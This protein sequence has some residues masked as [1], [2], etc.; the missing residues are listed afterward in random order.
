MMVPTTDADFLVIGSGVAGLTF[1][2]NVARHHRVIVLTKKD[3][4][5]S[6]SNYAQGGIA[7]V[8]SPED[9]FALHERDTLVAGAGLC[10]QDAVHVLVTEGPDRIHDLIALG[11]RFSTVRTPDGRE[12][13]E[14]GR[15]GGHSRN[16]IVHAVDRTG[17]ECERTLLQAT[18]SLENL[19]I[20]EHYFVVDLAL[21]DAGG[22]RRCFGAIALDTRSG[23]FHLFRA[24][25][26]LLATGG[27]GQV[28]RHTT[29]PAIATG[30]GVAMA[31]RAGATVAN[32]EFIQF[33]PTALYHPRGRSFLIS[34]A[35]RGEGG[36]LRTR[37]GAPFMAG[38]HALADLAPRD[39]VARAIH[40][41][42][43]KRG[44]PCVF[45]D[46][47]H[48]DAEFVK[49]RFPTIYER[50]LELGL[51]I[52]REWIPVVPAA[53]YQCG[54]V[55]TDLWGGTDLP[56]LYAAGEVACTGV[57]GANRLASNSLLEA[58]VFGYRAA[59]KCLEEDVLLPTGLGAPGLPPHGAQRCQMDAVEKTRSRLQSVMDEHVGIVRTTEGLNAA[60]AAI[61]EV[62]R[63]AEDLVRHSEPC[64]E[65]YE[66]RNMVDVA[67]LIVQSALTRRESRGLHYNTDYPATDDEHW[68]RDTLMK[69]GG[70]Q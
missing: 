50:C 22:E 23:E 9:E 49:R 68:K 47:T 19:R 44:E 64:L 24:R 30:D 28:Y 46:V 66:L 70:L 11:A 27:C 6:N 36:I 51:D 52:T 26:V 14:L 10:H 13:L 33:H 43:L 8:V 38:Y 16:R 1:A 65:L 54:G 32:M 12:V 17:W 69:A 42:R 20:L 57:H 2:L 60:L 34:E 37:D 5:E 25:C 62:R 4:A 63:D 39:I 35:V 59:R 61:H 53:H 67:A 58:M 31:Y 15:E 41:E 48:L 29:N 18:H 21:A 56:G 7:G 40:T 55:R 3:R 45:L